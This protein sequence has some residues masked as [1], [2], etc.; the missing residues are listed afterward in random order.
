MAFD[1]QGTEC[2][3]A[4]L[5]FRSRTFFFSLERFWEPIWWIWVV[6]KLYLCMLWTEFWAQ[7]TLNQQRKIKNTNLFKEI[8]EFRLTRG[9]RLDQMLIESWAFFHCLNALTPIRQSIVEK[10][11]ASQR[12]RGH[13]FRDVSQ[14]LSIN[15][16]FCRCISWADNLRGFLSYPV[17]TV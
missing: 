8:R 11:R 9:V 6:L 14:G 15:S 2:Y 12:K 7:R 4:D 10:F 16:G 5:F 3:W 1:G 13:C 17:R